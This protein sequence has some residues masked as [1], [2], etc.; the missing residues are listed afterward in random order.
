MLRNGHKALENKDC[1]TWIPVCPD[2]PCEVGDWKEWHGCDDPDACGQGVTAL[3][4]T[5]CSM[6]QLERVSRATQY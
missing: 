3:P 1:E 5:C 6:L 4:E 2:Q